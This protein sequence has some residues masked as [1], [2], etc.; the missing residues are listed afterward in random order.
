MIIT[1]KP[2]DRVVLKKSSGYADDMESNPA[3]G[4]RFG[5]VVGTVVDVEEDG[6]TSVD[7]DNDTHNGSYYYGNDLELLSIME[8]LENPPPPPSTNPADYF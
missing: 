5:K 7:W 4:G 2:G 8:V 3:W 6:E 1:L